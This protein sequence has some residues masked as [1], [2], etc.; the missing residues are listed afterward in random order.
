MIFSVCSFLKQLRLIVLQLYYT[1][2]TTTTT[3]TNTFRYI[4]MIRCS[5]VGGSA[6]VL[7]RFVFSVV[8]C[9][10]GSYRPSILYH[11]S[12]TFAERVTDHSSCCG[13]RRCIESRILLYSAQHFVGVGIGHQKVCRNRLCCKVQRWP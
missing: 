6:C 7:F 13:V 4:I 5:L 12:C 1:T 3:T 9:S 2:T 8:S 11:Q 10:L